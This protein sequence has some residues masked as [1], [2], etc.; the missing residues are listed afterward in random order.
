ME[1]SRLIVRR[2]EDAEDAAAPALDG[3]A[4]RAMARASASFILVVVGALVGV[5][6]LAG[7]SAQPAVTTGQL[8][9]SARA[10]D[11]DCDSVV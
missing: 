7:M 4:K 5:T 1:G 11:L 8:V 3:A 2:D 10:E 9:Q 6:M